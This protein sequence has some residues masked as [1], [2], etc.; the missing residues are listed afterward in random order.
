MI[1]AKQ[2]ELKGSQPLQVF[3][4]LREA[5]QMPTKNTQIIYNPKQLIREYQLDQSQLAFT[6]CGLNADGTAFVPEWD[7]TVLST[8]LHGMNIRLKKRF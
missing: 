4:P 2:D 6:F 3:Q 5:F 8:I 7:T 1:K